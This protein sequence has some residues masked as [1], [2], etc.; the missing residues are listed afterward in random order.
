MN[1]LR[2]GSSCGRSKLRA[3]P[4]SRPAAGQPV[5]VVVGIV[6]VVVVVANGAVVVV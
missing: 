6:V 4:V 2:T 1:G 3:A 5:V